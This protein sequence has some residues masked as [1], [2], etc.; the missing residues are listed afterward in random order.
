M[1]YQFSDTVLKEIK[2][3]KKI[4]L[5]CHRSPDPDS[6]GSAL[7]LYM[8]LKDMGKE[9]KVICPDDISDNCKFLPNSEVVEKVNF[10]QFKFSEYDLFILLDSGSWE[11]AS[12][13]R[14]IPTPKIPMIVIDHHMTNEGYGNQNYVD[15]KKS[16]AAEMLYLIFEDWKVK[17]NKDIAQLI[18]TGIIADTGVFEYPGVTPRTLDIAKSL[19]ERGGDKDLAVLN[20]YRSISFNKI[21][22]WG[23]ILRRMEIDE[24][25]KFI[26]AAIP[27]S[28]Y[29]EFD[30]PASA[31]D[32]ASSL[33]APV[34]ETTDFGMVMVEE[35]EK[36]LSISFRSR[37]GYDVS[38]LAKKLGGG[39]HITAAGARVRG[40]S[41]DEAV[42]KV[43]ETVRK[44]R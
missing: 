13:S 19:M 9:V 15:G 16:S 27:Y 2:K 26:W 34:V 25:Y 41:F 22:F 6:V 30:K 18:L 11:M 14:E 17:I 23:E 38:K 31:K 42:I 1:N 24:E 10:Y 32:S 44:N 43:L 7:S 4:L 12:G 40:L 21:K 35:E 29:E 37:T 28:L 39:G 36:M 8:V 5:N 3:A 20:I 33:F